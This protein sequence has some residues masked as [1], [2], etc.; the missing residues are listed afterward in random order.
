[1]RDVVLV[2]AFNRAEMLLLCLE[3][4]SACDLSD[5]RVIVSEDSRPRPFKIVAEMDASSRL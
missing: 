2:T 4:L 1:M 5:T 3:H